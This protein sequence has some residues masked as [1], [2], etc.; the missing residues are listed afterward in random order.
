M[1]NPRE[2]DTANM[3]KIFQNIK[4]PGDLGHLGICLLAMKWANV[5]N[6][7]VLEFLWKKIE[8]LLKSDQK[9]VMFE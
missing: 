5:K 1:N 8:V 6:G 7:E 4:I 3:T 9:R 2:D